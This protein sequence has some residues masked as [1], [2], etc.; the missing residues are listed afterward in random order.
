MG[1]NLYKQLPDQFSSQ[2]L[3]AASQLGGGLVGA[4]LAA[5]SDF[6]TNL[7]IIVVH[8]RNVIMRCSALTDKGI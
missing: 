3:A 5:Q 4:G 7:G 6:E 1:M 2:S 8:G